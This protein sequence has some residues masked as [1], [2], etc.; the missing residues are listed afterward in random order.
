MVLYPK[1]KERRVSLSEP[2]LRKSRFA[3]LRTAALFGLL[4]TLLF[5]SLF[6]YI[7]GSLYQQTEHTHN[8]NIVLV[9]YDGGVVGTAIRQAYH[10]L[11][12][13]SFPT[14][15]E[16][17][18][19]EYPEPDTLRSAVCDV[20]YWGAL[21]I[22]AGASDRL[23]S[24]LTNTESAS[25]YNRSDVIT[26]IW[27]GARYSTVI[28]S[29]EKQIETLTEAARIAYVQLNG[30]GALQTLDATDP[31]AIAA[32]SSP[33][34][35]ASV[36]IQPTTQGSRL[37][38]NTL[39][40]ILLLIQEFFFLATINGLYAQFGLFGRIK[41]R[42]MIIFRFM[43]SATYALAGSVCV[44]GA[45]W[46]FRAGWHVNGNQWALTWL[47]LWLFGHLTFLTLDVF[48]VWLPPPYVP[49]ALISWVVIN[50]TSILLPFE[51]SPAFYKWAY[52]VP[53]HA[54]YN[55]LID[56]WSGGCNPQ[57]S[58]ALPVLFAYE[59]S[60]GVLSGLGVYKRAHNAVIAAEREES[61]W[62][63]RID[64]AI[65]EFSRRSPSPPKT[66]E[67]VVPD[68]DVEPESPVQRLSTGGTIPDHDRE[69]L[70]G[71]IWKVTSEMN[72]EQAALRRRGSMG[73][74]FS[75]R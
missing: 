35:L 65:S 54:C 21:Y 23:A 31:A 42:R 2:A 55:I 64:K 1:A 38:Y 44:T 29:L 51:L 13:N 69:A 25:S 7:F 41:A 30:T 14:V 6:S 20:D 50:V 26:W 73:P 74:S 53:A 5:L 52:A 49:M 58:W 67:D 62:Q 61:T 46:A 75:L 56:I 59:L 36:N 28:D 33:W 15:I 39:V 70:A 71:E 22:S 4:L 57:L 45:I 17:S 68:Q 40:I 32:F 27:N 24:A 60:S 16:H 43:I 63:E 37:I 11:S 66:T 34:Q 19:L 3:F 72:E 9:D 18:P 12:S 8:L 47:T 10:Q 48:A